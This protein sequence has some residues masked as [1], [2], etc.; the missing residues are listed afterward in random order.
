MCLSLAHFVEHP[1]VNP[2]VFILIGLLYGCPGHGGHAIV[3]VDFQCVNVVRVGSLGSCRPL[4]S[5]LLASD[6]FVC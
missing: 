3:A 2:R 6:Y 5:E 4:Q 1:A